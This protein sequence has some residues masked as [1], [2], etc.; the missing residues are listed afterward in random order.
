MGSKLP[1]LEEGLGEADRISQMPDEVLTRILSF[2]DDT[3]LAVQT[4]V[5]SARWKN[6]WKS[7]SCIRLGDDDHESDDHFM[8]LADHVVSLHDLTDILKF[9]LTYVNDGIRG[10]VLAADYTCI[11][12]WICTIVQHNVAELRLN[13]SNFDGTQ[14]PFLFPECLFMS[15]T[16]VDLKVD[17][18]IISFSNCPIE[19]CFPRL[20]ALYVSVDESEQDSPSSLENLFRCCPVLEQLTILGTFSESNITISAPELKTLRMDCSFCDSNTFSINAPKLEN[21]GLLDNSSVPNTYHFENGRSPI[22]VKL[23][24]HN[25]NDD[26]DADRATALFA[27]ISNVEDLSLSLKGHT[28]SCL[29]EFVKLSRLVLVLHGFNYWEFLIECLRRCPNLKHLIVELKDNKWRSTDDGLEWEFFNPLECPA[30]LVSHL[31][32]I[33]I[34]GFKGQQDEMDVA[35]FLLKNGVVLNTTIIHTVSEGLLPLKEKLLGELLK[36]VGGSK[37][38]VILVD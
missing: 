32:T 19:G 20:K 4:M 2:L 5:L 31:Q 30:C 23:T 29:P 18:D 7:V 12:K 33:S 8:A 37:S 28:A 21:F 34:K 16:L 36:Y 1:K 11:R 25:D 38:R 17:S 9:D 3:V 13:L 35:K 26:F 10:D 6:L 24:L 14:D 15:T 27:Q 22:K